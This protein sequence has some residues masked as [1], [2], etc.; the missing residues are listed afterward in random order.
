MDKSKI[1]FIKADD[2]I[3][4]NDKKYKYI[5]FNIINKYKNKYL[6]YKIKYVN[7]KNNNK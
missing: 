7:F 2:N 5:S 6:K 1:S 4:I 3:I